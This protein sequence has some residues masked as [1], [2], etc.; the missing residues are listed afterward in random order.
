[1]CIPARD[2]DVWKFVLLG[3]LVITEILSSVLDIGR[4]DVMN[5]KLCIMALF[6]EICPVSDHSNISGSQTFRK[7]KL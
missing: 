1:M 2:V 4:I 5:I 7:F 3:P 6:V